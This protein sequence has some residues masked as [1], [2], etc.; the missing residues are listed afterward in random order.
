MNICNKNYQIK[1]FNNIVELTYP[2]MSYDGA[3]I[4]LWHIM[5][6]LTTL[7]LNLY[8]I[9]FSWINLRKLGGII[10]SAF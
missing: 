9:I 4:F 6:V 5:S 1:V 7:P 2:I 10:E 3:V 8:W